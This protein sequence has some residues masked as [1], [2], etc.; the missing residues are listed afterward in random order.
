MSKNWFKENRLA[1]VL[2]IALTSF[3][4][5]CIGISISAI[6]DRMFGLI[7]G[8]GPYNFWLNVI[9]FLPLIILPFLLSAFAI[10]TTFIIWTKTKHILLKSAIILFSFPGLWYGLRMLF[11]YLSMD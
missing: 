4:L 7:P 8:S 6:I 11:Y 5:A 1:F 10:I 2:V 9:T 3:V